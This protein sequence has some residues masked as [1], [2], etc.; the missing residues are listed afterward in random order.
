MR[1][2][3]HKVDEELLNEHRTSAEEL[4][5]ELAP[6]LP[7]A[8]TDYNAMF[9]KIL[10]KEIRDCG[11]YSY[12]FEEPFSKA[13]DQLQ[14]ANA[15]FAKAIAF[16]IVMDPYEYIDYLALAIILTDV[17]QAKKLAAFPR[18]RY[19]NQDVEPGEII[20]L[21]AESMGLLLLGVNGLTERLAAA[22]QELVSKKITRYDR[23]IAE[24]LI[25]MIEA[26]ANRDQTAFDQ[27]VT[28]RQES[29]KRAHNHPDER[30]MPDAL[31]DVSGLALVRIALA[32]GLQC[33][34]QS[35]YLPVELLQ[36]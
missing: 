26:I 12:A 16:G 27:V 6:D 5:R 25:T 3:P 22:Q 8:E 10:G 11:I 34:V 17:D 36:R 21:L 19:V 13:I 20:Y 23:A 28:A 33:N 1:K 32:R 30:N 2:Y 7:K 18:I 14:Q 35:P 29:F 9:F 24:T 31:L 15:C 4:I